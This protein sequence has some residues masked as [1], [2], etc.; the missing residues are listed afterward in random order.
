MKRQMNQYLILL[1]QIRENLRRDL[2]SS[3]DGLYDITDAEYR[4]AIAN[5]A[6]DLLRAAQLAKEIGWLKDLPRDFAKEC[7]I[8]RVGNANSNADCDITFV[9][10]LLMVFERLGVL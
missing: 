2:K 3:D 7:R 9:T 4:K 10:E 5:I 8:P 1:G 6:P